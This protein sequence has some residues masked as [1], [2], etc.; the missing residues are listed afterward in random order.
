MSCPAGCARPRP[1]TPPQAGRRASVRCYRASDGRSPARHPGS[2][3][4]APASPRLTPAWRD[5]G[6]MT[7]IGRHRAMLV[8]AAAMP[9]PE[10]TTLDAGPAIVRRLRDS[11]A[12]WRASQP[13]GE[14]LDEDVRNLLG[15]TYAVIGRQV[16]RSVTSLEAA[17]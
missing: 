14:L 15:K 13:A 16:I 5:G 10:P 9:V 12:R 1:T 2:S 17:T 11:T 4:V 6:L 8:S 3:V 7:I